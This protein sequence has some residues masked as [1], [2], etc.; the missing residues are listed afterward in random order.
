[1]NVSNF[2]YHELILV[3]DFNLNMFEDA[4]R[5][6]IDDFCCEFQIK[7]LINSPTSVTP[8]SSTCIDLLLT[9]HVIPPMSFL[10]D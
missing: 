7:Q 2:G 8:I 3:G 1:M 9:S 5:S 6:T 10:L 4:E